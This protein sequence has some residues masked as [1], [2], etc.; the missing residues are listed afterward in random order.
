MLYSIY[1]MVTTTILGDVSLLP[2]MY[3]IA[4]IT[5]LLTYLIFFGLLY[6]VYL[7]IKTIYTV[8]LS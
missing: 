5:M 8:V 7:I 6:F 4:D 3:M 2:D 1:E